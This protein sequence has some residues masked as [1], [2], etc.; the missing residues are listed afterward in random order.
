MQT[1]IFI[2][3]I[4]LI[5]LQTYSK[6]TTLT[7]L[8]IALRIV[9]LILVDQFIDVNFVAKISHVMSRIEQLRSFIAEDP[10]DIFSR[11]ALALEYAANEM[12]EEAIVELNSL[13][14]IS[15][16]YLPLYYQLGKLYEK[17]GNIQFAIEAYQAGIPIAHTQKN[18]RTLSELKSAL[19]QIKE[20]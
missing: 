5:D 14:E 2:V 6:R 20:D 15:N 16:D 3:I 1:K 11:Y 9:V 8:V 7:K 13:K 17:S 18:T 4:S 10:K 19:E 12:I